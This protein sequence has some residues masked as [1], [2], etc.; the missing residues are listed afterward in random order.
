MNLLF[1]TSCELQPVF[2]FS[3]AARLLSR[4]EE[5]CDRATETAREVFELRDFRQYFARIHLADRFV[6]R[7]NV[8]LD[9]I[10]ARLG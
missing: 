4:R 7:V 10:D 3:G 9:C 8:L 6:V 2:H 1:E 5:G